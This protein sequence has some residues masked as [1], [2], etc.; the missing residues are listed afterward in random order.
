[1]GRKLDGS[2]SY[3][4]YGRKEKNSYDLCWKIISGYDIQNEEVILQEMT[5]C[6]LQAPALNSSWH[7]YSRFLHVFT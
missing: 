3:S 6:I 7:K 2:Q 4:R 5:N 1:M